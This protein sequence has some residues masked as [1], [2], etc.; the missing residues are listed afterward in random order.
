MLTLYESERK[1]KEEGEKENHLHRQHTQKHTD[2]YIDIFWLGLTD[3]LINSTGI[4]AYLYGY[5]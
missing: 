1:K 2:S 3:C 4:Y 5:T